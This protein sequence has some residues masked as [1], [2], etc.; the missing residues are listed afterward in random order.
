MRHY[1]QGDTLRLILVGGKGG[2]GKTTLAAGIAL[3]LARACVQPKKILLV[4]TDP[5]HSLTDALMVPLGGRITPIPYEPFL[6]DSSFIS[7]RKISNIIESRSGAVGDLFAWEL[8]ASER[9]E[10]FRKKNERALRDLADRGTYFD[11]EDISQFLDLSIPGIDE[12]MA[13]LEIARLLDEGLYDHIVVDTA[14][15]GHTV[16]MLGLPVQMLQWIEVLELMQGKYRYMKTHITRKS[17]EKDHCD[18]FLEE[19]SC[20][21]ENLQR[22][23]G[24]ADRTRFIPV[25]LPE[26]MVIAETV[27]LLRR[28]KELHL[29][30]REIFVN[31]VIADSDCPW[32]L[33]R[34]K[35]QARHLA[36]A[37]VIFSSYRLIEIP[38]FPGE[39]YG[40]P[41]LLHLG[42]VLAGRADPVPPPPGV[43][44]PP[45]PEERVLGFPS[46]VRFVLVGGKGGVGKTSIAAAVALEL[47]CRHPDK[48][49]LL[50]SLDPAHSL[51]DVL[52]A[53][54]RNS[55]TPVAFGPVSCRARE[56]GLP[57]ADNLYAIEIDPEELFGR[58]RKE[59][60]DEI[61]ELFSRF[62]ANGF[63][64]KMDREIMTNL[65]AFSPPGLDEMMAMERIV[66]LMEEKAFDLYVLDTAPTGHFLRF[67]E[68]PD[69]IRRWA[70]TLFRLL[71]KYKGV[72]R[73][74]RL[75]E[76]ALNL[77]QAVKK[78]RQTFSDSMQTTFIGVT[79]PE[80]MA[81][82]EFKRLREAAG[83][84]GLDC[85]QLV[86]NMINPA[87]DCSF[88]RAVRREQIGRI[89]ELQKAFPS[90][91]I[92][93]A[94]L[95]SRPIKGIGDLGCMTGKL[96]KKIG[97]NATLI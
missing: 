3:D 84:T 86:V 48:K 29:S 27:R 24:N 95:F 35:E 94:P 40:V 93:L 20:Q 79:T 77:V 22:L 65:L 52:D 58:F 36:E 10:T 44:L 32:C 19:L 51:S 2:V 96:F 71:I 75:A 54:I 46:L 81:V 5:A 83:K 15:T 60:T 13:M 12:V 7:D 53:P 92:I 55:P 80:R 50:F 64:L 41:A 43:D 68:S 38:L 18:R 21:L 4:S 88:C 9:A 6:P 87:N 97:S 25:T 76:K 78:I 73:L 90:L 11:Q 39:V 8:D 26:P 82:E 28:L 42:D 30:V 85:G 34:K 45:E 14:P 56:P 49:V 31:R 91:S 62:L 59:F 66:G 47:A 74:S 57:F 89:Q 69:L 23:L 67:L 37:E 70:Y 61:N 17:W 63:D 1:L 16:R 33:L 72:V